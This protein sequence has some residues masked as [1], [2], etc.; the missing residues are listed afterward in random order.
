MRV[1]KVIL[2]LQW[3]VEHNEA[4]QQENVNLQEIRQKLHQPV[5]VDNSVSA[6]GGSNIEE[7]EETF[8]VFFPDGAMT[9]TNAGYE[10]P[11]DF[12][13]IAKHIAANGGRFDVHCDFAQEY[14][15]VHIRDTIVNFSA[16]ISLWP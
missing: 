6:Q 11:Q 1:H 15:G 7:Q 16:P 13:L 12:Q 2:A 4:W 14:T 10:S 9:E 5:I 8:K 3:L